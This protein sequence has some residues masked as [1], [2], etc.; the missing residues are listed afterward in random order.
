MSDIMIPVKFEKLL[1]WILEEYKKE[2]TIFGIHEEKFY[3]KHDKSFITIFG[4]KCETALGPAAG[5]HTQQTPNIVAAYLTGSRFFELKTVQILDELDIEKPCIEATDE[6]YNTEWSTELTVPQAYEEYLK[7]WFLI[8]V[9]NKMFGLSRLDERAF[10][11][12]T[13]VGYDL[14]GIKQKKVDDFIENLKDASKHPVFRECE[15]VLK[16]AISTGD[17]PGIN[18]PDF[19]ETISPN[20]S[21]SITLSTMHGCPPEDQEAICKYLMKEKKLHTFLKMNPTLH[22]YE[23]VKNAFAKLGYDHITLKEES[24]THDM[25][26]KPAV[27]MLDVLIPFAKEQGVEFGAKLSNTLAVV[28]DQRMLPTDEMYMSGRALF[29]LTINLAKKL[30][31]QYNGKLPISYAGGANYFNA[32]ELFEIGIRPITIATDILKPGGYTKLSQLAY[33]L[34]DEM[35]QPV[36]DRIDL[37]K[38]DELA[39]NALESPIYKMETKSQIPMKIDKKLEMMKCFIA[40]CKE[41]CP[42]NQDVP[43]YIRLIGEERYLE[44]YELILS[45]NPLPH[46]T[47]FICDHQCMFKCV[48][49][50]Y[51]EPV[52]IRELKRVA[53][54]KGF[55]KYMIKMKTDVKPIDIKVA[56]IGAGPAGLSSAHFLARAGFDVTVFDRTDKPGGTVIHTIPGFRIPKWAIDNDIE[57]IKRMGVKFKFNADEDINIANL[58]ADGF[59][60]I[61]LAIGAWKS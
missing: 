27:K 59:K 7:G 57:L 22:G 6:G 56:I 23:Y 55:S 25:Q 43:E 33:L 9:V 31:H 8:H 24:F 37:S 11:F 30:S 45:K 32:K 34:D 61:N 15:T 26:W 46:I 20:I 14:A 2:K 10:I 42:I 17:I 38:L 29:P 58:K 12:N 39:K 35:K 4:E 19:V 1:H 36:K 60:Y 44:A 53:A 40:P 21:N 13:S 48:R 5:P 28:N 54:E 47:G 51:E 18:D 49:N 52:L 41:A 3:K 16:K 50:D